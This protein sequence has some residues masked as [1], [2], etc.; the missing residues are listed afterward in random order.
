MKTIDL[1]L[2]WPLFA[3]QALLAVIGLVS[4][5]RARSVRGPKWMWVFI[6]LLGNLLGSLAY[7]TIGRK[8]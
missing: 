8:E 6:I 1:S 3:L 7:F 2:L 4:L 5:S